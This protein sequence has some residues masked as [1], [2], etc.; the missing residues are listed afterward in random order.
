M[1]ESTEEISILLK[2]CIDAAAWTSHGY[3]RARAALNTGADLLTALIETK[4]NGCDHRRLMSSRAALQR[5]KGRTALPLLGPCVRQAPCPHSR[6]ARPQSPRQSID[7]FRRPRRVRTFSMSNR[8][9][10]P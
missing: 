1:A 10:P 8:F 3:H 6:C 5:R 2:T 9:E 7:R 4:R